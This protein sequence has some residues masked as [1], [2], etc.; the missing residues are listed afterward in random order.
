MMMSLQAGLDAFR[1]VF[2]SDRPARR[3]RREPEAFALR[4]RVHFDYCAV[5][6]VRKIMPDL[7]E[8]PDCFQNFVNRIGQP[9]IFVGWQTEFLEQLEKSSSEDRR[10]RLR[11]AP[12]P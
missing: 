6:L 11:T 7:I 9:P 8:V 4:E 3:F 10:L 5:G 1:R 12:V 2:V